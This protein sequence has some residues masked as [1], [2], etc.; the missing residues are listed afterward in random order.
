MGALPERAGW[1]RVICDHDRTREKINHVQRR[2]HD[3]GVY[4]GAF[5][6]E[7]DTATAEAVQRFQSERHIEHGG[8]LSFRTL[9]ALDAPPTPAD[10]TTAAPRTI[11]TA[12]VYAP[13]QM[14]YRPQREVAQADGRRWLIWPGKTAY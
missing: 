3:W 2:L 14:V 8:Y 11:Y 12:P 5:S 4:S 6:G 9:E 7:F 13:V 1:I 10:Q